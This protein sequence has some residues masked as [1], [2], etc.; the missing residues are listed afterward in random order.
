MRLPWLTRA[1]TISHVQQQRG[2]N[3]DIFLFGISSCLRVSLSVA[4]VKRSVAISHIEQL[5]SI[6]P[7]VLYIDHTSVQFELHG[8]IGQVYALL[9][10][11]LP[12][13]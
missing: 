10:R 1:V 8:E 3:I 2:S 12:Q 7:H 5:C 13:Y 9:K 11:Y 4:Q 6:R